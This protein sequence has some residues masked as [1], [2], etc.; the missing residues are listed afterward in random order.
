MIRPLAAMAALAAVLPAAAPAQTQA[1]MDRFLTAVAQVDCRVDART[2][3]ALQQ[4][5]GYSDDQ[6]AAIMTRLFESRSVRI[7]QDRNV[8][9]VTAG[10]CA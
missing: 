9:V 2:A 1:E 6:L 8:V 10:P 4:A 5:L 7:E 3:P